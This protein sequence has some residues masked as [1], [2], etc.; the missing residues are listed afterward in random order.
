MQPVKIFA[1]F[2]WS[3][4]TIGSCNSPL[5]RSAAMNVEVTHR[6]PRT[7]MHSNLAIYQL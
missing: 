6:C 5:P 2:I 3:L 7:V 1:P 4:T